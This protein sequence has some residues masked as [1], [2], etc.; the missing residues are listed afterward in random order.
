MTSRELGGMQVGYGTGKMR[1]PGLASK[2]G[3]LRSMYSARAR[4][5]VADGSAHKNL[6]HWRYDLAKSPTFPTTSACGVQAT[7]SNKHAPRRSAAGPDG[8]GTAPCEPLAR[9]DPLEAASHRPERPGSRGSA[10]SLG[11]HRDPP[12]HAH[13]QVAA[14]AT[15]DAG[16]RWAV[17]AAARRSAPSR[18]W[19]GRRGGWHCAALRG[20]GAP[21]NAPHRPV[22]HRSAIR[23]GSEWGCGRCSG[24]TGACG[25]H[26]SS[27]PSTPSPPPAST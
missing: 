18:P 15:H 5:D 7:R 13:A 8:L 24:G 22:G 11:T 27:R 1:C 12:H 26:L 19:S 25:A 4:K 6:A 2:C 21:T 9:A 3:F 10:P 14:S 16:G 20:G 23:W 17:C